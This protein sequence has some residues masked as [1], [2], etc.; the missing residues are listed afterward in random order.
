MTSTVERHTLGALLRESAVYG[1]GM[2]LARALGFFLTPI[3]ARAF[4]AREFGILDL[5]QTGALLAST[6]LSFSMESALLRYYHETPDRAPLLSTYLLTQL[7]VGAVFVLAVAATGPG[8]VRH[9]GGPDAPG[10]VI[11][12]GVSVVTGLVY[13]HALT[14]LRAERAAGEA[15]TL[16]AIDTALNVGLVVAFLAGGLGLTA[17]FLAR[18]TSDG[19]C[20]AGVIARHRARYRLTYSVPWLRRFL[21]FGLPLTPEG[22]LAF[23]ASQVGK[24]FV[25]GYASV[26]DV[27]LLAVA[28]R[29][30]TALKLALGSLRQAWL[31]YAYS[32]AERSDSGDLYARA[33]RGYTRVALFLLVGFVLMSREIVLVLA[34]TEYLAS[35]PLLG[36][37]AAAAVVAGLP[38]I[39]NIGLLLEER[40]GY[41]T[42][43]V[44]ASAIVTVVAGW[45]LIGHLG[46]VGA[47]L[48]GVL[49][50]L[51]MAAC[52]LVFAQRVRPIP[53][54]R[55][56]VGLFVAAVLAIGAAGVLDLSAALSLPVRVLLV[57]AA[58]WAL[59]R[60]GLGVHLA[61]RVL[62]RRPA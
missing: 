21:R 1:M 14:M 43:G 12:A 45:V 46:V 11:A 53:Y 9:W 42:I 36:L 19:L 39:F 3:L 57:L 30:A 32:V 52:V 44:V 2:V 22:V 56:R 27:G 51:V 55:G 62:Q 6:L 20:A 35:R 40:T 18:A 49:G 29:I 34:G 4:D 48:S 25:L 37:I 5:L 13:T 60:A 15:A 50:S 59:L 33:F 17:V 38:Y 61:R 54:G 7:G 8:L 23:S 26:A 41:Y 16:I 10:P 28:N 31:P 58:A 24:L 47:P